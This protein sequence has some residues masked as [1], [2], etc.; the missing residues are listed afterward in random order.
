[1][2]YAEDDYLEVYFGTFC[3]NCKHYEEGEGY[4]TT[5]NECLE[6]PFALNSHVPVKF[7]DVNEEQ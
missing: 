3:K 6:E 7:E 4:G 2:F 1:M 5:C